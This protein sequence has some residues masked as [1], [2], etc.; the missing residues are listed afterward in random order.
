VAAEPQQAVAV[1]RKAA[2]AAG[3]RWAVA[4]GGCLSA[5]AEWKV[6]VAAGAVVV[7]GAVV[8]VGARS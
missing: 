1:G 5:D 7:A 4:D 2:V 6:A 3:H 8:G